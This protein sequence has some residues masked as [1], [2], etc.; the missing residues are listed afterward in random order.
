[1]RRAAAEFSGSD[2]ARSM[3]CWRRRRPETLE[4][5]RNP[6]LED[7]A[8]FGCR[9]VELTTTARLAADRSWLPEE[10]NYTPD[11][12]YCYTLSYLNKY[13]SAPSN[14]SRIQGRSERV[15][16]S[17]RESYRH[18][19]TV[20]LCIDEST[21]WLRPYRSRASCSG[22]SVKVA[23]ESLNLETERRQGNGRRRDGRDQS[24]G[25]T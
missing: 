25:M 18:M 22:I 9:S 7:L 16:R 21:I 3:A 19:S 4:K 23:G 2:G 14:A 10:K 13:G 17:F 15:S 6:L 12:R 11:I 5:S 8:A 20:P 1:M 24:R